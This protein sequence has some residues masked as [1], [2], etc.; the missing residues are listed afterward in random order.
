MR[1]INEIC[2]LMQTRW[3]PMPT[4]GEVSPHQAWSNSLSN[5]CSMHAAYYVSIFTALWSRH[6]RFLAGSCHPTRHGETCSTWWGCPQTNLPPFQ[7]YKS[8]RQ[9]LSRPAS[10]AAVL[11]VACA[12][13]GSLPRRRGL[14][15]TVLSPLQICNVAPPQPPIKA[16]ELSTVGKI[17][18][19]SLNSRTRG[20]CE[21]LPEVALWSA[22]HSAGPQTQTSS[23][24]TWACMRWSPQK[25][26]WDQQWLASGVL[27]LVVCRQYLKIQECQPFYNSD[28]FLLTEAPSPAVN[29]YL[30]GD[31]A[32][33]ILVHQ[34]RRFGFN[35]WRHGLKAAPL[36]PQLKEAL[37]NLY[38]TQVWTNQGSFS[39]GGKLLAEKSS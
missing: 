5:P 20:R 10:R 29:N 16:D 17:M 25:A 2:D 32:R 28:L 7:D 15:N 12:R 21:A 6:L 23:I 31:A 9:D 4:T 8:L 18:S 36:S 13:P 26:S 14:G 27:Q 34:M 35:L 11:L 39:N 38:S 3:W 33:A 19:S 1:R 37:R 30:P 22:G 24:I